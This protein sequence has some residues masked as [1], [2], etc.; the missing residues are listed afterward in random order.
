MNRILCVFNRGIKPRGGAEL[1]PPW[2]EGS[3]AGFLRNR[4][5]LHR[6]NKRLN[7]INLLFKSSYNLYGYE[8][9]LVYAWI[10]Y[11]LC[12]Y[13]CGRRGCDTNNSAPIPGGLYLHIRGAVQSIN[14]S[15]SEA[16]DSRAVITGPV[17]DFA[18]YSFAEICLCLRFASYFDGQREVRF[19][20]YVRR[21]GV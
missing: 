16:L 11:Y 21:C 1:A 20:I 18:L 2:L 10:I 13:I 15:A 7:Y 6:R 17:A 4:P 8:R 3:V 14:Q 19:Q 9:L 5:L 12:V